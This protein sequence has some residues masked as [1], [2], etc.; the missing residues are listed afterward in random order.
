MTNQLPFSHDEGRPA[1]EDI[2]EVTPSLAAAQESDEDA[3]AALSGLDGIFTSKGK[4]KSGTEGFS[5]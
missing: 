4:T 3:A 1:A 5:W 2:Q